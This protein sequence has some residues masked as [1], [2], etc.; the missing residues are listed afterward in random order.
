MLVATE[1]PGYFSFFFFIGKGQ[2]APDV[3]KLVEDEE[4]LRKAFRERTE[5]NDLVFGKFEAVSPWR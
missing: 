5:R 3:R 4:A 1:K 2:E